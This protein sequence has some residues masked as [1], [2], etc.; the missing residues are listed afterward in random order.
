MKWS[1]KPDKEMMDYLEKAGRSGR[2]SEPVG[3]EMP[4]P[5]EADNGKAGMTAYSGAFEKW[6][7]KIKSCP[8]WPDM[9][10]ESYDMVGEFAPLPVTENE[11]Q[12]A[13]LHN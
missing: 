10:K 6:I 11:I 13:V 9:Y 3:R 7:E 4:H 5:A 2:I 8:S 12:N 1:L